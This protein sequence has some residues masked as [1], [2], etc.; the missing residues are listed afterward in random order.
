MKQFIFVAILFFALCLLIPIM[1]LDR[2]RPN[3]DYTMIVSNISGDDLRGGR[4][5]Q[6]SASNGDV[7][8]KIN[9]ENGPTQKRG[10]YILRLNGNMEVLTVYHFPWYSATD[11]GISEEQELVICARKIGM[12]YLYD[13][14]GVL[15]SS[16]KVKSVDIEESKYN[17]ILSSTDRLTTS[18]GICYR[19]VKQHYP[20]SISQTEENGSEI[21]REIF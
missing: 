6:L 5:D 9:K 15:I 8:L 7:Y 13:M 2:V 4:A 19:I 18:D 17:A 21:V 10:T 14:N 20:F 1:L 11:F 12:L 3:A 16:E